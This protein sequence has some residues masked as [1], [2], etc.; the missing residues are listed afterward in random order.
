MGCADYLGIRR[1]LL[2]LQRG[3][4]N[5]A[6]RWNYKARYSCTLRDSATNSTAR[7]IARQASVAK[8]LATGRR[9]PRRTYSALGQGKL[10]F[11]KVGAATEEEARLMDTATQP[12][13]SGARLDAPYRTEAH[14]L[15]TL[16]ARE[17]AHPAT[18]Q[19]TGL[20]K[21]QG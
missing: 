6:V 18:S 3:R 16:G 20:R 4:I 13:R 17:A 5:C 7:R 11:R 9:L 12:T 15:W 2:P 14:P 1:G 10:S 21:L 19:G 8:D